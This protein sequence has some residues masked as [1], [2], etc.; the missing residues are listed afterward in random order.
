VTASSAGK[1]GTARPGRPRDGSIR[2][3]VIAA[4]IECYAERGWNG[5]NFEA[6]SIKSSVGRPALY[7]RWSDREELL[8]D[9]F[10]ESTQQLVA[11]DRGNVRDDLTEIALAHRRLLSGARGRAGLRLFI[12]QETIPAVFSA[13]S[14]E[15]TAQRDALIQQALHQGLSRGEIRAGADLGVAHELLVGAVMLD[16]FSYAKSPR[17]IRSTVASMVD[18]LLIGLAT[19]ASTR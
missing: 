19:E 3:K 15:I 12:E 9:A 7:R 1:S 8:V 6:V 4:A 5:F 14:A 2:R 18:T 16:S 11:P 17:Q 13:V 10:R